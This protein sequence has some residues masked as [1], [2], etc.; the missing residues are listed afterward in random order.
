MKLSGTTKSCQ[1]KP[2]QF[3]FYHN[4]VDISKAEQIIWFLLV[5]GV[6]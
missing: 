2:H 4:S 5:W 3:Y 1:A 6:S